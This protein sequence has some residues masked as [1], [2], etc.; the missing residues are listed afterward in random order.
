[1]AGYPH[2]FLPYWGYTS[3]FN[4]LDYPSTVIPVKDIRTNAVD[5]PKDAS[6]V[7]QPNAFDTENYQICECL[8]CDLGLLFLRHSR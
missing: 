7:P 8:G 1:M 5:D 3:L 2:D 6:Y 4:L